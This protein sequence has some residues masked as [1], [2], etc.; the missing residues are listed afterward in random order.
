MYIVYFFLVPT[1]CIFF[2]FVCD[3]ELG[4]REIARDRGGGSSDSR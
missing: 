2:G 1:L 3:M 4:S